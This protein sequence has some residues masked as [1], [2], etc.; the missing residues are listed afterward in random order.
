MDDINSIYNYLDNFSNN[1]LKQHK[2]LL[3]LQE[4]I[5]DMDRIKEQFYKLDNINNSDINY[6]SNN[7]SDND[8]ELQRVLE[9]SRNE[10]FS[11]S[12]NYKNKNTNTNTNTNTSI[13]SEKEISEYE[14]NGIKYPYAKFYYYKCDKYFYGKH[15]HS[16][17][18]DCNQDYTEEERKKINK[19]K[20]M[21]CDT[22]QDINKKCIKCKKELANYYCK[23]CNIL[24]N[25]PTILHCDKCNVCKGS[26]IPNK[27]IVHCNTCNTCTYEHHDCEI[28]KKEDTECVICQRSNKDDAPY[29]KYE[30]NR[31][32]H[33]LNCCGN[34]F[35]Y[36]CLKE[37]QNHGRNTCPLCRKSYS[38]N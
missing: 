3:E 12:N 4:R 36:N 18:C 13:K 6:D 8:V 37:L 20:C 5:K 15:D 11:C 28:I 19:M 31:R 14:P 26:H 27:K 1:L 35:H 25:Y 16:V 33:K 21:F 24:S 30:N 17:N 2:E 23:K 9:I 7:D 32:L 10:Y 29:G 34:V 22:I 38:I